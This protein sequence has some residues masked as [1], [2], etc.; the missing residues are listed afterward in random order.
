M[1][2]PK[3]GKE[4][5]PGY[6]SGWTYSGFSLWQA[7]RRTTRRQKDSERLAGVE[8]SR[9]MDSVARI[10]GRWFSSIEIRKKRMS[11]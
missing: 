2:C 4:M 8:R 10:V 7:T 11:G 3:C 5:E 9:L 6:I 1:I